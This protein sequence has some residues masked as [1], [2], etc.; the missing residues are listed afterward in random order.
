MKCSDL[1]VACL[2]A[3]GIE[4]IFGVPGEENADFMIS[5]QKSERIRFILTRQEQGATFMADVYGR[6]TH[7]PTACLGTL[8]PGATNLMTGVANANMDHSPLLCLTGQADTERLHKESHQAMDIISMYR[9]VTK[10]AQAIHH[11]DNTAEIVRKAVRVARSEKPGACLVELPED[12]ANREAE[13]IP[14]EPHRYQQ[15]S[16][17]PDVVEDAWE[18]IRQAKRPIIIAGAGTM[19]RHATDALRRFVAQTGIG[20]IS[21]FMAKGAVD[22]DD[23]A[24]IYTIGLQTRDYTSVALDESDLVIT[25]GY[26]MVEYHPGLWNKGNSHRIVHIDYISSE[27]DESYRTEIEVIGN[28]ADALDMLCDHL[29]RNPNPPAFDHA[30]TRRAR[31]LI[32]TDLTWYKDD[33]TVGKIKPQK[34]I[35][36]ARQVLGHNDI[37][38]SDVGAHKMWVARYFHCH[39]PNTYLIENGFCSMGFALPGAIAAQLIYP[40][41]RVLAVCGDGGMLMNAQEMETAKR[42]GSNIVAMVWEDHAYGLISWKQDNEFHRHTD[43]SFGN[44]DWLQLATAFDWN[45]YACDDSAALQAT[46]EQTFATD[47]PSLVVIPIDYRENARLTERLGHIPVAL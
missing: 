31:K 35:W 10:W 3:E 2:E 1:L 16:P 39:E 42:L 6:L 5:L 40:E 12:I 13:S 44:P 21:T 46:L 20:V 19:R 34:A 26:D 8:G 22:V 18:I 37:L 33:D 14:I 47:G 11:P 9:P 43:L 29:A 28:I 7:N 23:E 24:C 45:G 25:I 17:D 27:I 4:Y 30:H 38:L 36:D 41:R 32:H 15:P